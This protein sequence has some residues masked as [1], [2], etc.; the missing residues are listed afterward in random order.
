[1]KFDDILW[2]K[3]DGIGKLTINRPDKM[4]ALTGFTMYEM[5]QALNDAWSDKDVGEKKQGKCGSA[6]AILPR[7]RCRWDW[8]SG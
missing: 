8:S 4:N 5:S 1:M 3:K 6:T 7:R 2:E